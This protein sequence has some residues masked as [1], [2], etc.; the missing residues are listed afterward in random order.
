VSRF[1]RRGRKDA[2]GDQ[3][4]PDDRSG[5]GPD[6]PD[7]AQEPEDVAAAA[8]GRPGGP[9]DASEVA[10]DDTRIDLGGLRV[11]ARDGVEVRLEADQASGTVVAVTLVAEDAALQVQPFAAPRS[12]GIWAEVRGEIRAGITKQGGTA[13]EVEGPLGVE[14]V[15]RVPLRGGTGGTGAQPARFLGVDGPR[16]F[17]R[18]VLSGR[19]AVEHEAA[20]P[21]LDLF[22]DLVVVRGS[23]P[24][25]PRDPIPLRLPAEA[26]QAADEGRAGSGREPLGPLERGPEITE[27]R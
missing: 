12:E 19:A 11:P 21:L 4:V 6:G 3:P 25:A 22:R 23:D 2:A 20:G 26:Q 8:A 18:G 27:T 9:W 24:M 16:W 1:G 15:T 17:L 13:D 10:E 5:T 14:L 7:D